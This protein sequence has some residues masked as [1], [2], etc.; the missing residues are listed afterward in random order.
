[1]SPRTRLTRAESQARTRA[2]LLDAAAEVF[3]EKGFGR[4]SLEEV[5]ARA[6]F[7]RGAVYSNFADK[8]A[9]FVALL[10]E[11]LSRRIDEIAAM[12]RTAS[13]PSELVAVLR[14]GAA[15]RP[16]DPAW[17]VLLAEF[18]LHAMREPDARRLLVAHERAVRDEL[19][20][21]VRSQLSATG[22][23]APAPIELLAL[24]LQ[25]LEHGILFERY[26]DP[27]GIDSG[28]YFDALALLTEALAGSSGP[29][30]SS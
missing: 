14:A 7:T 24:M 23:S 5:A 3:V 4:A 9:L 11:R 18:W 30:R 17:F 1:M 27:D 16:A 6:G 29:T 28:A 25:A 26:L 2:R 15:S 12:V 13:S 22:L 21:V 19:G 8:S 20:R 10:D